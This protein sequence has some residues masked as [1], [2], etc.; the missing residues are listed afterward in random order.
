MKILLMGEF[1]GFHTALK[2]GLEELGHECVLAS[3][4]DNWKKIE[5]SNLR[6]FRTDFK[7]P[8][9]KGYK[10]VV[11]PLFGLRKFYGFDIVQYVNPIIYS[12]YINKIVFDKI[13]QHS[14][15]I[16][17]AISG[18]CHSLFQAYEKG[19][20]GYYIYDDNPELCSSYINDKHAKA[21]IIQEEY[22]Y[23]HVDGIIPVMY[24]YAV[25][26]KE[27]TNLLPTIPLPF[28]SDKIAYKENKVNGKIVIMHGVIREKYKGTAY[29]LQ[30]LDIIKQRY[31]N[32]VEIIVDGK[33][34][35]NEYLKVLQRT[36]ILVDQCKEHGWSMN[37]CH[38]MAQGK[39]VLSGASRNTL[40]EF[41]LS[42]SPVFHIKPDVNQIV[43]Q[44][45]YLIENKD[46]IEEFGY[47]S[48]K[49]VE[50][51]HNHRRIAQLY[52]DN[53]LGDK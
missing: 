34:P 30:A 7:N 9:D 17:T 43:S 45:E 27:R 46:K 3:N 39:V 16:F 11:E 24:E 50:T 28:E 20:L 49:F 15:K 1:S 38:G 51:F 23:N 25:G 53:W 36:N 40:K 6:L 32:D 2:H 21:R 31:P 22:T 19:E 5:G 35:L 47:K 13:R 37:A 29:I 26:V 44:L 12:P 48:R 41:G 10:L 8:I 42:S 52:L 33:L 18:D 14:S 4:G